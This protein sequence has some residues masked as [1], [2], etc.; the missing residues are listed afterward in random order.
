MR[1]EDSAK[2]EDYV[3]SI[4]EYCIKNPD[5][6]IENA[7]DINKMERGGE[8]KSLRQKVRALMYA[9][10]DLC[11]P[12]SGSTDNVPENAR[13]KDSTPMNKDIW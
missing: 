7:F 13:Y 3:N 5:C 6:S 11:D 1:E 2:Y 4:K 12:E 8:E 10:R 9:I